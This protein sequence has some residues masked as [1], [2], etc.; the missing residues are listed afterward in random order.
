[1]SK[2][3]LIYSFNT[4]KTAQIADLIHKELGDKVELINAET[5]N[6]QLFTKY[7][8][9]ILGVPTWFDGELPNYWDEFVPELEDIDLKSFK[10]AIFGNGDQV[11]YAENFCDGI[12][13]MANIV[14]KCGAQLVGKTSISGYTFER[15]KSIRDGQFLGLALDF[16]NQV[17]KNKERVKKWVEQIIQEFE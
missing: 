15:T 9:L 11:N 3:G 14:E 4:K 1:M 5:V 10:V 13:L 16:E 2:I 12:G 6:G 17:A 8:S 7:K